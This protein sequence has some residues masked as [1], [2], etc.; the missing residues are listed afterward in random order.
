LAGWDWIEFVQVPWAQLMTT[1]D[2]HVPNFEPRIAVSC[3]SFM[4]AKNFVLDGQGFMIELY[5]AVVDEFK[6]G[7][8]VHLLPDL[9]LRPLDVFAV[10]PAKTPKDSLARIYIDF[11]MDQKWLLDFGWKRP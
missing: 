7:K 8:L 10:Y 11:I 9:K 5:P 3:D 2:G 4:M 1:L 6:F